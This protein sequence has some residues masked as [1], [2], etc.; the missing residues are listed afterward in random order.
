VSQIN[1]GVAQAFEQPIVLP[2]GRLLRIRFLHESDEAAIQILCDS[3][4]PRTQYLRFLSHFPTTPEPVVRML[5]RIDG[6]RALGLVAM[7]GTDDD[8]S[9]IVGLGNLYAVDG[10][11]MEVGLVVRDDWQRQRVGTELAHRMLQVAHARG[12]DR[13]VA[14]RARENVAIRALLQR[15]GTIVSA[16]AHGSMTEITFVGR[17]VPDQ[18]GTSSQPRVE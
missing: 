5:T 17:Q 10:C 16:T 7:A 9:E 1:K 14:Y 12:F 18:S 15:H 11:R 3:L 2:N 6:R 13:F 4:S 8:S